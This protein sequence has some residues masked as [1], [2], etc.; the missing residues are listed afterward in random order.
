MPFCALY[1]FLLR[2]GSSSTLALMI[3]R[4]TR[5]CSQCSKQGLDTRLGCALYYHLNSTLWFHFYSCLNS[6]SGSWAPIT[7]TTREPSLRHC[8]KLWT[9]SGKLRMVLQEFRS[10]RRLHWWPNIHKIPNIL[11]CL[12]PPYFVC[13]T[14]LFQ[15]FEGL[16][17]RLS[18]RMFY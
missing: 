16:V 4:M 1:Q 17:P 10:S 5:P 11:Q 6:A 9:P 14:L 7:L 12:L 15:H 8:G 13:Q 18:A 2:S 3:S